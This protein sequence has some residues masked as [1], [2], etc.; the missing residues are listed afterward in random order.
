MPDCPVCLGTVGSGTAVTLDC[1][2]TASC[3]ALCI[4]LWLL[5]SGSCPTCR[6]PQAARHSGYDGFLRAC[7]ALVAF[8]RRAG[9]TVSNID[10]SRFG[11]DPAA[12]ANPAWVRAA[13]AALERAG[14]EV[15]IRRPGGGQHQKLVVVW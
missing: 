14:H 11:Q 8:D 10:C 1:P 9:N 5:Q 13:A 15:E 7:R 4:E 6:A 3:C 2:C 12:L